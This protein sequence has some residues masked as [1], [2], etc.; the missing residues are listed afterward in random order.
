M[1]VSA[2]GAHICICLNLAYIDL[3]VCTGGELLVLPHLV[4]IDFPVAGLFTF[5]LWA[6]NLLFRIF[7]CILVER[8][9]FSKLQ[10]F[11]S[12]VSEF[13][14]AWFQSRKTATLELDQYQ[15]VAA[16]D[17]LFNFL[18]FKKKILRHS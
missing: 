6:K 13:L 7:F 3:P 17:S 14:V 15:S 1:Y 11:G 10:F 4:H 5:I 12:Q 16:L 8:L 9:D 18:L 2:D